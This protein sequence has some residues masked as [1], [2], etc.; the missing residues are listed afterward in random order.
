M[1]EN[2][3]FK[4]TLFLPKNNLAPQSS[5]GVGVDLGR[6]ELP[7]NRCHRLILPLNYR[8]KIISILSKICF[9]Y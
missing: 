7:T 8:P 1:I 5:L 4:K 6:I 3:F 9:L 2:D